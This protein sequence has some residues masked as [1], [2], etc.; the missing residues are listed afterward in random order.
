MNNL[1]CFN[2]EPTLYYLV[3]AINSIGLIVTLDTLIL[4]AR[5]LHKFGN[6]ESIN[7]KHLRGHSAAAIVVLLIYLIHTPLLISCNTAFL[8]LNGTLLYNAWIIWY[9]F[10]GCLLSGIMLHMNFETR[11]GHI[12]KK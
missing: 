3:I 7:C 8:K 5:Y 2:V 11:S 6:N 4:T 9:I 10:L 12:F 1:G